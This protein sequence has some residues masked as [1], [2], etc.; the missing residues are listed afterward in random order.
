M[1][2]AR[3][4]REVAEALALANGHPVPTREPVTVADVVS[5]VALAAVLF[6]ALVLDGVIA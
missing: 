4:D 2:A 3:F 1:R 6:G 5:V